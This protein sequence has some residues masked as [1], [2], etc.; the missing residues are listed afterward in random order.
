MDTLPLEIQTKILDEIPQFTRLSKDYVA[1]KNHL[2]QLSKKVITKE[3]FINYVNKFVPD[4]FC[5]FEQQHSIFRVYRMK[6]KDDLYTIND[7]CIFKNPT[8]IRNEESEYVEKFTIDEIIDLVNM[9][10]GNLSYD[11]VTMSNIYHNFRRECKNYKQILYDKIYR[12]PNTL[13][14]KM[15]VFPIKTIVKA[16][17]IF[18]YIESN[19]HIIIKIDIG[20]N[21]FFVD[22]VE[23]LRFNHHGIF[24]GNQNDITD[25]MKHVNNH[26]TFNLKQI[27]DY[28]K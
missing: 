20:S 9:M 5:V 7:Y 12:F 23:S 16:I 17:I 2:D 4:R 3:E 6:K 14:G 27:I 15:D 8:K 11:T 1:G 10:E 24:D 19:S 18:V 25:L 21:H 13:I 22:M 26:N 28:L